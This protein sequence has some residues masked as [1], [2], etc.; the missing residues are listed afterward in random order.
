L[1]ASRPLTGCPAGWF[2]S[3]VDGKFTPGG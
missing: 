3:G 1:Q 2:G